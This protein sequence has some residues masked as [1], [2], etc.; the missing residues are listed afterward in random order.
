MENTAADCGNNSNPRYQ[1]GVVYGTP[2]EKKRLLLSTPTCPVVR[3][4]LC[5]FLFLF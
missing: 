3:I 5:I 4:N 2:V 1:F